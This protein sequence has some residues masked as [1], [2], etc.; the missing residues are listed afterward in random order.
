MTNLPP[1]GNDRLREIERRERDRVAVVLADDRQWLLERQHAALDPDGAGQRQRATDVVAAR[2][3]RSANGYSEAE[4]I[5]TIGKLWAWG[6]LDGTDVETDLLRDAGRR[7]AAVYWHRYG[8]VCPS[9]G[10]YGEMVR[11][12]TGPRMTTIIDPDQDLDAENRFRNRDEALRTLPDGQRVKA[13]VDQFCVDGAGDNDPGW[14]IDMM[15][16]YEAETRA[17]RLAVNDREV[18]LA[19]ATT[20]DERRRAQRNLDDAE[21]A[22]RRELRDLRRRRVPHA[23]LHRLRDGLVE[24][25]RI[26]AREGHHRVRRERRDEEND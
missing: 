18:K 26:D 19:A 24:L 12:S 2:R 15:N 5:D 25:M 11:G 1:H 20:P 8:L 17:L 14:L 7:Y 21:R 13:A 4:A 23:A 22:L 9:I 6:M 3:R 10:T 16:G